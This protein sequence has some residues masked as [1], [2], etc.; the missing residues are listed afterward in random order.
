MRVTT[1]SGLT[2]LLLLASSLSSSHDDLLGTRYVAAD[3]IDV[4]DC[5]HA[6]AP[7]KTIAYAIQQTPPGGTVKVAEGF[8]S[9][10]GPGTS[11]LGPNTTTDHNGYTKGNRNYVSWPFSARFACTPAVA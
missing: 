8:F 5:D 1:R 9:V 11:Y 6:H 3:G 10:E 2:T 4:G 7:C